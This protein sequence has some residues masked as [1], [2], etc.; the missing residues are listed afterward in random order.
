MKPTRAAPTRIRCGCDYRLVGLASGRGCSLPDRRSLQRYLVRLL[1][2]F[3]SAGVV[4]G[5]PGVVVECC[6]VGVERNAQTMTAQRPPLSGRTSW[7]WNV[8]GVFS[9]HLAL[10]DDVGLDR[11]QAGYR[12]GVLRLVQGP[13]PEEAVG[14]CNNPPRVGEP[15]W[16]SSVGILVCG[17]IG[18][19][20]TGGTGCAPDPGGRLPSGSAGGAARWCCAHRSL[21]GRVTRVIQGWVEG[22]AAVTASSYGRFRCSSERLP[23]DIHTGDNLTGKGDG[24]TSR[25]E[26]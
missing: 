19:L 5:D 12:D 7:P 16:L 13:S 14:M 8:R 17:D 21:C 2:W 25:S 4:V 24:T 20:L 18:V 23:T 3:R 11:T 6:G 9:R 10:G 26:G 1:P 22:A 15:C